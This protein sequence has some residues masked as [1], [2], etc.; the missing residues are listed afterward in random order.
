MGWLDP[1]SL[2][3]SGQ[4][5][6]ERMRSDGTVSLIQA[7]RFAQEMQVSV[8]KLDTKTWMQTNT[9]ENCINKDVHISFDVVTDSPYNVR[10]LRA[11]EGGEGL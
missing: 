11:T 9:F 5:P 10:K 8:K 7:T 6:G 1:D 2:R 4:W 3:A